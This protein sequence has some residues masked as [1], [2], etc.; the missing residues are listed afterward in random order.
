MNFIL[1]KKITVILLLLG[2]LSVS[3]RKEA[4]EVIPSVRIGVML[5]YTGE[6][7]ADW[8]SGLDWAVE[9]INLSGGINGCR[10]DW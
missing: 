8:D 9:N 7:A 3:C 5:P 10:L 6:Y 2:L 4:I 1:P